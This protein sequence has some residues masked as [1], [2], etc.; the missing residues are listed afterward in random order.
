[1]FRRDFWNLVTIVGPLRSALCM[2]LT[3]GLLGKFGFG[4]ITR[5]RLAMT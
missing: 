1:M 2:G 5:A 4:N 3:V